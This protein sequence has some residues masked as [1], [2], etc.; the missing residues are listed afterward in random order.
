METSLSFKEVCRFVKDDDP[1]LIDNVDLMLGLVL[2]LS[3]M[4]LVPS[5]ATIAPALGLLAVKNELT[6]IGK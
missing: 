5:A 4:V 2:I 3:P 6:K 1:K